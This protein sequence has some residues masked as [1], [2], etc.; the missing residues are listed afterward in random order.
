MFWMSGS[1]GDAAAC[2]N[3]TSV[4]SLA[5]QVWNLIC[6]QRLFWYLCQRIILLSSSFYIVL[7]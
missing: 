1:T 3:A 5:C 7:P 4:L 2:V 6:A